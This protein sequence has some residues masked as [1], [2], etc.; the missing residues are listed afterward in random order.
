MQ[1]KAKRILYAIAALVVAAAL[2]AGGTFAYRNRE[3]R[4]ANTVQGMARYQSRLVEDYEKNPEWKERIPIKKEVSIKNMGGTPQF[5]GSNWGPIYV[6]LQLLEYM[7]ITPYEY[8]YIT[9]ADTTPT[10]S[11]TDPIRF[12]VDTEGNYVRFPALDPVTGD[13]VSL[14][15]GINMI[16]WSKV[17]TDSA[18]KQAAFKSSVASR[19]WLELSGYYDV[20]A[21]GNKVYYYYLPTQAGDPNGQ[22]GAFVVKD[23]APVNSSREVITGEVHNPRLVDIVNGQKDALHQQYLD[24]YHPHNWVDCDNACHTYISVDVFGTKDVDWKW[25]SDWNGTPGPFWIIDDRAGNKGWAYWGEPLLPYDSANPTINQTKKLIES[26][27][28]KVVPEDLMLYDLYIHMEAYSLNELGSMD[29]S[30]PLYTAPPAPVAPSAISPTSLNAKVG[31]NY[32][33]G[34]T[35]SGTT[36]ITWALASGSTMPAGM[37]LSANGAITGTP[38]TAGTYNVAVEATNAAGTTPATTIT[39]V[40][41]PPDGPGG[42]INIKDNREECCL[43]NNSIL[44]YD[45]FRILRKANNPVEILFI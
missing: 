21:A 25:F 6:G 38:T 10:T 35:A 31:V 37:S 9:G 1:S 4:K 24:Y 16:D 44:I 43:Q 5:P 19:Q 7:D 23:A 18:T 42:S 36:P 26:I 34:L 33:G 27:T 45:W 8:T 11:A 13:P 22:Y 14:V 40:V 20:D 17:I 30:H 12:M 28:P 29:P 32:S 15:D 2:V 41:S 3:E 39:I